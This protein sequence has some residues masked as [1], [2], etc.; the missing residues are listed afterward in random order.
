MALPH[1]ILETGASIYDFGSESMLF[2][3]P[4]A[5]EFIDEIVRVFGR[6]AVP[7]QPFAAGRGAL[8]AGVLDRLEALN[9]ADFRELFEQTARFVPDTLA[10]AREHREQI[11]KINSWH[12]SL[13]ARPIRK[14]REARV[15]P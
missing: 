11:T 9:M 3:Q 10:F 12:P 6:H 4:F 15:A 8:E 7:F 2:S 14:E 5:P 13:A 1:G